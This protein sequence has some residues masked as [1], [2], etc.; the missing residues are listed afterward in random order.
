MKKLRMTP[1]ALKDLKEIKSY[2]SEELLSEE[3]ALRTIKQI[4]E[5]YE[6]LVEFPLMGKKLSSVIYADKEYRFII[7]EKYI[8]FYKV[9]EEF[10]SIYRILYGRRN[11]MEILFNN[12]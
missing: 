6:R 11:Y 10:I 1:I 5:S 2:I 4:I 7:A 8:I 9:E 3:A 12:F